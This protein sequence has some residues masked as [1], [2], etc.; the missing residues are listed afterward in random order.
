MTTQ[1]LQKW[2]KQRKSKVEKSKSN[3]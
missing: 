1:L 2:L 3:P